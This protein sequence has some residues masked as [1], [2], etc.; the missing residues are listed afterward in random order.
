MANLTLKQIRDAVVPEGKKT[1]ALFDGDGLY[2]KVQPP[3][4]KRNTKARKYWQTRISF[5]S[6]RLTIGIG[7]AY[8]ITPQEA[9]EANLRLRRLA[10]DGIDPRR[11]RVRQTQGSVNFSDVVETYLREKTTEFKNPKHIQQWTNTLTTY[12]VEAG[13]GSMPVAEI[14]MQ[15]VL[16]VLQ[17]I[18][19][20]K[21]ETAARV[22]G[23]IEKVLDSAI[24]DGQLEGP[25]PAL[26]G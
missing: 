7:S 22:R 8:D 5:G 14:T 26:E 19:Q 17:P 16:M 21:T 4:S 20:T 18:W 3:S 12:A 11:S 1:T 25:N 6:K 23:R 13:L 2:L 24:A 9:R 10:R 15:D